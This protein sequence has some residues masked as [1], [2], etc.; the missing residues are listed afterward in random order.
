M[1]FTR[2]VD[3]KEGLFVVPAFPLE[4]VVDTTGAGDTF[5]AGF[6]GYLAERDCLSLE[7]LR[8]AVVHGTVVASFTVEDFSID[9]LRTLD[10]TQIQ[11]RYDDFRYLTHFEPLDSRAAKRL[12][13]SYS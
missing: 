1:L 3:P 12:R 10:A 4:K 11:A 6:V 13:N 2:G 9:R 8:R 7:N 5:A